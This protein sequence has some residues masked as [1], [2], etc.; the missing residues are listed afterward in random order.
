M[1]IP[2]GSLETK[3]FMVSEMTKI[4]KLSHE[5]LCVL[6]A[7]LGN[8]LLPESEL[9]EVYRK[10][11]ISLSPN[12][13][14]S[15][16]LVRSLA[17]FVS[18]LPPVSQLDTLITQIL[19]SIDDK[20]ASALRQTIQYYLNGTAD[21]FLKYRTAT[22]RRPDLHSLN[23]KRNNVSS[24][25]GVSSAT[26]S[27]VCVNSGTTNHNSVTS[28]ISSRSEDNDLD[29]S[30][31]ASET[32]EREQK[33]LEDYKLATKHISQMTPEIIIEQSSSDGESL[34]HSSSAEKSPRTDDKCKFLLL[35][36]FGFG[37]ACNTIYISVLQVV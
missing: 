11:G 36:L 1:L 4:L 20:R 26:G 30:G 37:D 3:E 34:S 10:A 2:Q 8:Y 25:S 12:R 15:E 13:P 16:Q 19:G 29:T 32:T 14:S 23:K 7:L 31:F 28:G 33:S 6:A 17:E 9:V 35:F 5:Q 21:G 22:T 18:G 27:A 24:T